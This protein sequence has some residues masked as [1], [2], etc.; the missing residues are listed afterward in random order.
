MA[1]LRVL[2]IMSSF[3]GGISTFIYNLV[4]E[5]DHVDMIFD[6][7]TYSEVPDYFQAMIEAKGGYIYRLINPKKAGYKLFSDS[8]MTVLRSSDYQAIYCH[9]DGYRALAYYQQVR[10]HSKLLAKHFYIHAHHQYNGSSN[11]LFEA[12][13]RSI[14]LLVNNKISRRPV[15]C[16][17]EAIEALYGKQNIDQPVVIPNSIDLDQL[18]QDSSSQEKVRQEWRYAHGFSEETFLIGQI[19]RLTPVKGHA[20]SLEL[21]QTLSL[22]EQ[23]FHFLI[24]GNGELEEKLKKQ[25]KQL[26]ISQLVTFLGRVSPVYPLLASL[27]LLILPSRAEGL[28]TVVIEAQAVGLPVLVSEGVPAE[29]DLNLGLVNRLPLGREWESLIRNKMQARSKEMFLDPAIRRQRLEER[30]YSNR[31]AVQLIRQLI[32][33][34]QTDCE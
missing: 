19:G 17:L 34:D 13:I 20:F 30:N 23:D 3:G 24:A 10:Q 29:V 15:G 16:S 28:G 6:V 31:S 9:I 7:A 5:I 4:T 1:E 11:G 22:V 27:D 18:I 2:H 32:D 8:I 14:N 33:Q 12:G 26:G 21:M 25:A